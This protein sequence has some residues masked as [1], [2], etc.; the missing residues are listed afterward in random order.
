MFHM[1]NLCTALVSLDL[2]GFSY[3]ANPVCSYMFDKTGQNV[4]E[5]PINIYVSEA[6]KSYLDELPTM[7]N[8]EYATLVVKP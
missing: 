2:S 6:G 1:F 3:D 4:E 8:S 7:I 5:K